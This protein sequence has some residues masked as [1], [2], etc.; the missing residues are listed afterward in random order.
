MIPI[1]KLGKAGHAKKL[2]SCKDLSHANTIHAKTKKKEKKPSSSRLSTPSMQNRI[3]KQHF[4]TWFISS[5]LKPT[6]HAC[7]AIGPI[8]LQTLTVWE[9]KIL[10]TP[11]VSLSQPCINSNLD[12]LI[13]TH[14]W[15]A[16]LYHT[17]GLTCHYRTNLTCKLSHAK[18]K[19]E[20]KTFHAHSRKV[21]LTM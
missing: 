11:T 4:H 2:T 3:C 14:S 8:K 5:K 9:N 15:L 7:S 20:K 17:H 1:S 6:H 21:I 16:K 19:K 13:S 12:T 10:C 18:T